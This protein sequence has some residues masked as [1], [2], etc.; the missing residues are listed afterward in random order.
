VAGGLLKTATLSPAGSEPAA[1][2][3]EDITGAWTGYEDGGAYFYR[4]LLNEGGR[5]ACEVLFV[6][7]TVDSYSV[8]Q[9]R[10][11][12]RGLLLQLSPITKS[13]EKVKVTVTHVDNLRLEFTV[14]GVDRTWSRKVTLYKEAEF[15]K[16]LARC[17]DHAAAYKRGQ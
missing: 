10:V 6:D 9:W 13:A 14:V 11:G 15:L 16:R 2:T 17:R 12:P 5:G 3:P 4:I 7:D 8:D 1:P